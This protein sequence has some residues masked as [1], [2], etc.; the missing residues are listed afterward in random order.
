MFL[1]TKIFKTSA[2]CSVYIVFCNQSLFYHL[3]QVSID[4]CCS[5]CNSLFFKV[6]AHI[7]D[8]HVS[9]FHC[10]Q[11]R[12]K[13][14][15]LLCLILC[16]DSHISFLSPKYPPADKT[17][18]TYAVHK[19]SVYNLKTVFILQIISLPV[20]MKTVFILILFIKFYTSSAFISLTILRSFRTIDGATESSS[21]PI[22]TNCSVNVVS[23]PSS[24]QIPAH[25]PHL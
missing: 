10:F 13:L 14:C 19:I 11:I 9:S 20:N 18:F 2:A 6:T 23:A 25:L 7:T 5:Y 17:L 1:C 16:L 3:F 22:R 21:T 15:H 24:P 12:Q 8:C 4:G